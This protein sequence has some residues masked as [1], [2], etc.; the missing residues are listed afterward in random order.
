M[1][2]LVIACYIV[3]MSI[4][5]G[6]VPSAYAA[7]V[8]AHR[9]PVLQLVVVG[10]DVPCTLADDARFKHAVVTHKGR[11]YIACWAKVDAGHAFVVDETGDA[12]VIPLGPEA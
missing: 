10:H 11:N 2:R 7:V 12:G 8:F 1:K 5:P 3:I 4:L 9:D 6:C